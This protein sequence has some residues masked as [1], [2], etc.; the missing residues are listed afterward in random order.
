VI[1]IVTKLG[2]VRLKVFKFADVCSLVFDY[3]LIHYGELALKGLNRPFFEKKLIENVSKALDGL[4]HGKIRKIQGRIIL[5]LTAHS[6]TNAIEEA[7]KK[8]FG[9]SWF[10]FCFITEAQLEKI[11]ELIKKELKIKTGEKVKV[12][13][14]RADKTLPF[15][16]VDVNRSLGKY[17]VENFNIEVSL[18]EP[19]REIFV[20]LV[21]GKA[22]VFDKKFMGLYGLPVGVSGKILHLLSGGIDS[23]VAAWLL[24]KRG[25]QVDFLH[26]HA[27]KK[28]DESK[29]AKVLKLA[30][31]LTQYCFASRIFFVPFYPFQVEAVEANPKYRLI[32]FRRFMLKVAEELAKT[33]DIPAIGTGENIAQVSSQTLENIAVINN[34]TSMPILRPLLTY[35]KN[36]IVNLAKQIGTFEISIEPYKDCCSLFITKHPTTKAK[37]EIV[38][39]MEEK[40]NLKDAICESIEKTVVVKVRK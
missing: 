30:K 21:N 33:N 31:F 22:Y 16:S 11:E 26:F 17:L 2:Y 40:M 39:A 38:K 28:Y 15:T 10:A 29:N 32:L 14:K 4:E 27:F 36:E 5:E 3:V 7:L 1:R 34:A 20:E 19:E 37:L 35:E 24:M 6:N 23:P 25:C 8:V 13:A 18:K 12:S 9:V